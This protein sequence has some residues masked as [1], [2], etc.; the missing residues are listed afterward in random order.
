MLPVK[1]KSYPKDMCHDCDRIDQCLSDG[2]VVPDKVAR[3][4]FPEDKGNVFPGPGDPICPKTGH[5]PG[6]YVRDEEPQ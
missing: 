5:C 1:V 6:I 2:T 4:L 3:V